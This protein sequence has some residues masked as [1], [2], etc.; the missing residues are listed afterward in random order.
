MKNKFDL[1]FT[2]KRRKVISVI[3]AAAAILWIILWVIFPME[4]Y[5]LFFVSAAGS[6]LYLILLELVLIFPLNALFSRI[7]KGN[8][9]MSLTLAAD[10]ICM[11]AAAYTFSIFRYSQI[12]WVILV[13]FLHLGV[14]IYSL[15]TLR[16]DEKT[17]LPL[18]KRSPLK[19]V[20]TAAAYAAALDG[21]FLLLMYTSVQVFAG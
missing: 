5:S 13:L 18:I 14:K 7:I 16:E 10:L 20:L 8:I 15:G 17:V 11:T 3:C 12:W 2:D 6:N 1:Y 9:P 4:F 21:A 19:V